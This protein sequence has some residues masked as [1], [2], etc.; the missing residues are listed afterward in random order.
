MSSPSP[1]SPSP[2]PP[3]QAPSPLVPQ[4]QQPLMPSTRVPSPL[5][6][7][8][9]H[10]Q[11]PVSSLSTNQV[12]CPTNSVTSLPPPSNSQ[13]NTGNTQL[14]GSPGPLQHGQNSSISDCPPH[15]H[16]GSTSQQTTVQVIFHFLFYCFN[17]FYTNFVL[18]Y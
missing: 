10:S 7:P 15:Q 16:S 14:N 12:S 3:P 6:S 18:F 11:S 17:L 8:Q 1:H 2:M 9:H 4:Q 13:F 5:G